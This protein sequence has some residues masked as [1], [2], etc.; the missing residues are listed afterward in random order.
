MFD[1]FK[2]KKDKNKS[3]KPESAE[4]DSALEQ[5]LEPISSQPEISEIEPQPWM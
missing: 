2:R 3:E 5:T 1:F 4:L